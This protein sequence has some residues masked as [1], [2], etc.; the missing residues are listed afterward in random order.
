MALPGNLELLFGESP[1]AP[2]LSKAEVSER[3]DDLIKTITDAPEREL[4]REEIVTSFRAGQPV[5]FSDRPT[6]AYEYVAK[7]LGSPDLAKSVSADT[8][9]SVMAALDALK[10]QQPDLVKDINLTSPVGTG[11][12]A[13]D[14]EA[15]SF[16]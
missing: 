6:N 3:F 10:G 2:K 7:A 11:L 12:V 13:F 8:V 15:P 9:A 4:S 14:L 5:D 1:E 16:S